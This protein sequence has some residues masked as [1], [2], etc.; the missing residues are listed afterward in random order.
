M[1]VCSSIN[2]TKLHS[3]TYMC[4]CVYL[5]IF[6]IVQF[7]QKVPIFGTFCKV[8]SW[9]PSFTP[10]PETDF[11]KGDRKAAQVP[12]WTTWRFFEKTRCSWRSTRDTLT[13]KKS[14]AWSLILLHQPFAQI[15][16]HPTS[17]NLANVRRDTFL[18]GTASWNLYQRHL[19]RKWCWFSKR[20]PPKFNVGTWK[21]WFPK[22][23]SPRF[24]GAIFRWTVLNFRGVFF[25]ENPK[26]SLWFQ[27]LCKISVKLDLFPK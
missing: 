20:T 5:T 27:P 6:F 15:P 13:W 25:K 16:S 12:W 19:G 17:S 4:S 18:L 23:G 22:P 7:P 9:S 24:Q 1:L 26:T 11:T 2:P 14:H 10:F 21:W 3:F 8:V